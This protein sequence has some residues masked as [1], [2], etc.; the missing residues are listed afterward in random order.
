LEI[1]E[2]KQRFYEGYEH[3][4]G[5]FQIPLHWRG[6]GVVLIAK[7][8]QDGFLLMAR[9]PNSPPPEITEKKQSFYEGYERSSRGGF[10]AS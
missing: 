9:F 6:A 7:A 10:F 2:K 8:K 5:V 3:S 1:T 4:S